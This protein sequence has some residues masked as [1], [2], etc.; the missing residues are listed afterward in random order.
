MITAKN[1]SNCRKRRGA[2]A[3]CHQ[4]SNEGMLGMLGEDA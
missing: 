3:V 1:R 2:V 4:L